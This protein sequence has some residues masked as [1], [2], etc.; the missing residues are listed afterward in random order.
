MNLTKLAYK[1]AQCL[2]LLEFLADW[3]KSE[4]CD[5]RALYSL[6]DRAYRNAEA[7]FARACSLYSREELRQMGIAA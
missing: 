2:A 7:Q 1:R 5:E 3:D 6:A 4:D